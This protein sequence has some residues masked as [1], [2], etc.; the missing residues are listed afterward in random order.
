[1]KKEF[2][3]YVDLPNQCYKQC[4]DLFKG[5]RPDMAFV[6]N[7]KVYVLELTVC[8][9][10]NMVNSRDYKVN[11]YKDLWKSKAEI[12]KNH[13]ISVTTCEVSAL[14]FLQLDLEAM[15]PL[16][17]LKCENNFRDELTSLVISES[18]NIYNKRNTTN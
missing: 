1:M 5:F 12:I 8:H 2:E 17:I 10:T 3:L 7:H 16:G 9:E 15:K 14:G 4:A 18:F 11:K 13:D 6:S